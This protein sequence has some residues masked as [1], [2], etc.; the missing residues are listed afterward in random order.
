MIPLMTYLADYDI[1]NN[2]DSFMNLV[3]T[4]I[5]RKPVWTIILTATRDKLDVGVN[6]VIPL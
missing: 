3:S 4:Y 5:G 2:F 6:A 1:N